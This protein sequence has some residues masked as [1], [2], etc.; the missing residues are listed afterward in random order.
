MALLTREYVQISV[1]GLILSELGILYGIIA[2]FRLYELVLLAETDVPVGV[3]TRD[4]LNKLLDGHRRPLAVLLAV[5]PFLERRNVSRRIIQIVV[6]GVE[7]FPENRSARPRENTESKYIFTFEN[8]YPEQFSSD[9]ALSQI[10][11]SSKS[12]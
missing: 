3:K 11:S 5:L 8:I 9:L 6:R 12:F 7:A 2:S 4:M 10:H 1:L